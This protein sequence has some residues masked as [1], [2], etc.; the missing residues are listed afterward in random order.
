MRVLGTCVLLAAIALAG[1][2]S[3]EPAGPDAP[4]ISLSR[5]TVTIEAS[6]GAAEATVAQVAITNTGDAPLTS[7]V[8]RSVQLVPAAPAWLTATLDRAEAPATLTLTASSASLTPGTYRAEIAI[9]MTQSPGTTRDVVV[10]LT[11][12]SIAAASLEIVAPAPVQGVVGARLGDSV[13]VRARDGNG[14]PLPGVTVAFAVVAGSGSVSPA[15][16]VTDGNGIVRTEWTLG[17]AAME[18]RMR[19][20][21]GG[22][23]SPDVVTLGVA[24]PAVRLAFRPLPAAVAA[25]DVIAPAVELL[26][27]YGNRSDGD[28]VVVTLTLETASVASTR[29]VRTATAAAGVATFADL[30]AYGPIG[31][32]VLKADAPGLAGVVSDAIQVGPPARSTTDRPDDASGPQLHVVYAVPADGADRQLDGA[33]TLYYSIASFQSWLRGK[34]GGRQLLFDTRHGIVDIT[35]L[36]MSGT[37]ASMSASPLDPVIIALDAAG[38][39]DPSRTYLVY[40]DGAADAACGGALWPGRVVAMYLKGLPG[41]PVPCASQPFVTSPDQFPGYWEFAT[42]H[43]VLHTQGIVDVNAPHGLN[44]HVPEPIDLMYSGSAPWE[45]GPLLTLDV[46]GDDYW[47]PLVPPGIANL[48]T[49]PILGPVAATARRPPGAFLRAAPRTSPD[50]P[51]VHGPHIDR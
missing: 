12:S 43:D 33:T 46:G 51:P 10:I 31:P 11:V 3:G 15:S 23:A 39:N 5:D 38:L 27:Q 24:G 49:V 18:N 47:G 9:G 34:T 26:D 32:V 45:L 28:G 42:L 25:G 8:I 19:A 41:G 21:A 22:I 14:A 1:C 17:T 7:L 13:A 37:E 50:P 48:A 35:F 30:S 29:G 20:T 16:G 2:G 40:Y 36:R 6:G 4:I 44:A